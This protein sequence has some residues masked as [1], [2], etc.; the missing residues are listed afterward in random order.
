[1]SAI[2]SSGHGYGTGRGLQWVGAKGVGL[3]GPNTLW[4]LNV[5]DAGNIHDWCY[6]VGIDRAEADLMFL[7]NMLDIIGRKT[8]RFPVLGKILRFLRRH[9][10]ITYYNMA[11]EGGGPAWMVAQKERRAKERREGNADRD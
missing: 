3:G 5:T 11:A 9:R 1:M 6:W 2:L 8:T 10:A 4:G 7:D